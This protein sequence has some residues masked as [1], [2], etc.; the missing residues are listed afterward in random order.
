MA[1][2]F[3]TGLGKEFFKLS[4]FS[5]EEKKRQITFRSSEEGAGCCFVAQ[6]VG[7]QGREAFFS[8]VRAVS[9]ELIHSCFQT[10]ASTGIFSLY[11]EQGGRCTYCQSLV[12]LDTTLT[13]IVP[14]YVS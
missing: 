8:W 11:V 3:D 6:T 12:Q 9:R 10:E 1:V 7:A 14:V 5:Q 13:V 4:V 2:S